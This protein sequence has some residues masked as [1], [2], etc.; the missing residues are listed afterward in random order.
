MKTLGRHT[1][2]DYYDC[3]PVVLASSDQVRELLLSAI[4][5]SGLTI[6]LDNFHHFAPHGVSG[7]VVIAE[8][9][10]TIHTWPEYR[11]AAVDLFTCGSTMKSEKIHSLIQAGLGSTRTSQALINRGGQIGNASI[12]KIAAA[13]KP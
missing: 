13:V 9:H 2:I 11:Y 4:Q 8:S 1:L 7:V 10:V 3:D 5:S 6:V 12:P